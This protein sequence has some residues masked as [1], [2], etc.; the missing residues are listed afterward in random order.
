MVGGALCGFIG[1]EFMNWNRLQTFLLVSE[2][3]SF[4]KGSRKLGLSQS[5]VS[6]Q[7]SMLEEELKCPLFNRAWSGLVLTEAGEELR[8]TA[9]LMARD[10]D[11]SVARINEGRAL[12]EGPLR[13]STTIAFGSSWLTP[14]VRS[15]HERY[16]EIRLSLHLTDNEYLDLSMRDADCAIR[17]ARQTQLNL[18]QVPLG[19][20]RYKMYA[21]KD[22]V[23]EFGMPEKL[24]DLDKHDLIVYGD[25]SP[26]PISEMNWLLNVGREPAE[27]RT[28]A[29]EI[30]SVYGIF[31]A[32]EV[33][34][35]VAALPYYLAQSSDSLVEV[36]PA[37]TGPAFEVLFVYPEELRNL[38]RI[39][40][41]LEFLQDQAQEDIAAGVLQPRL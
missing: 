11:L 36:M 6:R 3:G 35:G 37:I 34:L 2:A 15:F 29:L 26:Q 39:R 41:L 17:F 10:L 14:R 31:R 9:V 38:R 8:K 32:A 12:A 5:A 7:I 20:V 25:F 1:L 27:P 24:D 23:A 40:V 4:S 28:A 21:S 19:V 33:G 13:V 30:S 22:Y 18:V 16:H